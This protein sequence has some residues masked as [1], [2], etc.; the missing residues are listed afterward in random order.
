MYSELLPSLQQDPRFK[1]IERTYSTDSDGKWIII[2][3]K[4][5]KE[6]VIVIVDSLIVKSSTSNTN[7]NKRPVR[8][9]KYNINFTLVSYAK[10]LPNKIVPTDNSKRTFSWCPKTKLPNIIQF[11][12]DYRLSLL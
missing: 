5:S 9:T 6:A 1:D 12:F 3:T 4:D 7:P 8:S 11:H 2:T 10:M